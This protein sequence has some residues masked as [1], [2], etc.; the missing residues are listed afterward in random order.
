MQI[1]ILGNGFDLAHGLKTKYSDFL[2]Y[3]KTKYDSGEAENADKN[4]NFYL[5]RKSEKTTKSEFKTWAG[6]DLNPHAFYCAGS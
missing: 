2:D 5:R 4:N 3:C 1:L 6:W